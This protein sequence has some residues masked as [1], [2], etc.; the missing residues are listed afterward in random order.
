MATSAYTLTSLEFPPRARTLH[1]WCV[2]RCVL[3]AQLRHLQTSRHTHQA[4]KTKCSES[5]HTRVAEG[6]SDTHNDGAGKGTRSPWPHDS[7]E[8]IDPDSVEITR[9]NIKYN[10]TNL[11]RMVSLF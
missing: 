2:R 3:A 5:D 8:A 7:L 9:F 1:R 10:S 6:P 4:Y 11:Y